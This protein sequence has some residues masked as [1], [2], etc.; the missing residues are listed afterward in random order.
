MTRNRFRNAFIFR[1][2]DYRTVSTMSYRVH[3]LLR[4]ERVREL[5]F[6]FL[7]VTGERWN[8]TNRCM[9]TQLSNWVLWGQEI[10]L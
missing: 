1:F 5:Q 4:D 8:T 10:Q 3:E 6:K 2:S 9:Y 7:H